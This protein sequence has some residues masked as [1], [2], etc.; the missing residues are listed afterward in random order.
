MARVDDAALLTGVGLTSVPRDFYAQIDPMFESVLGPDGSS[1]F[2]DTTVLEERE[3]G[4]GFD[5]DDIAGMTLDG[6]IRAFPLMYDLGEDIVM[7]LGLFE[8]DNIV[9]D[10]EE[11][12]RRFDAI[13]GRDVLSRVAVAE[14]KEAGG[15]DGEKQLGYQTRLEVIEASVMDQGVPVDELSYQPF[16]EFLSSSFGTGI[17]DCSQML[18]DFVQ[19]L[20]PGGDDPE[21]ESESEIQTSDEDLFRFLFT[22]TFMMMDSDSDGVVQEAEI[23]SALDTLR[24]CPARKERSRLKRRWYRRHNWKRLVFSARRGVRVKKCLG[25]LLYRPC[26]AVCSKFGQIWS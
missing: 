26:V 2:E 6:I 23:D 20:N 11:N 24:L 19:D 14:T 5:I 4:S 9:G 21:N 22:Q 17:I 25:R 10:E 12:D 8:S 13:T 7:A 1:E 18:P 16:C 3:M 15:G